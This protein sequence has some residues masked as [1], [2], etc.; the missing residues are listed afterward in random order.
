M[1]EIYFDDL[2]QPKLNKRQRLIH[3]LCELSPPAFNKESVLDAVKKTGGRA[4][5][6]HLETRARPRS[7][8]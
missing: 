6:R 3:W 7:S 1:K 5:P 2:E 4:K 8:I